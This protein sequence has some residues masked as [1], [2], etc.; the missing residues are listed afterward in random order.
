METGHTRTHCIRCGECCLKS[1]PTLQD[2]DLPQVKNGRILTHAL[3]TIRTGEL[4]RDNINDQLKISEFELIKFKEKDPGK[5]CVQYD[6][7]GQGCKIYDY[8][9][10]QC[11][12]QTCWDDSEYMQV[13]NGPKLTRKTIIQDEIL[14]G[15]MEQHE[16]RCD[17]GVLEKLVKQIETKG[18]KAV[19][20]ILSLLKF[21]HELRP[22][23]SE[24]MGVDLNDMDFIFGRPLTETI[25][26]F[27]LKVTREPD[28]S[29]FLTAEK[30][31]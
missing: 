13:Y 19:E 10:A 17:Y 1:S 31:P 23:V 8:R 24:K 15:L 25:S 20:E 11:A 4:V 16:K 29:F 9:P 18:E 26:M 12:A 2:E 14:L 6:E 5:G 7:K 21:D 3:Y 30:E 27:G 22:F 28:G